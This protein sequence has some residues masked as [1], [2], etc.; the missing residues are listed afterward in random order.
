MR[1]V[2]VCVAAILYGLEILLVTRVWSF[3]SCWSRVLRK[4]QKSPWGLRYSSHVCILAS[5]EE[6]W[7]A[8]DWASMLWCPL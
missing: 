6:P 3:C 4:A 5:P 2:P 1:Q 8:P 7:L